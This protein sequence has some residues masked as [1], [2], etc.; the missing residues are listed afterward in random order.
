MSHRIKLIKVVP[1]FVIALFLLIVDSSIVDAH[2]SLE[3][4]S[5]KN[6]EVLEVSPSVIEI[7]FQDPVILHS[8][9]VKIID[10]TGSEV[11]IKETKLSSQD[12]GN[13]NVSLESK[14]EPGKYIVRINV[15]ALD[16]Y[17]I[18]EEFNFL[19][20]KRASVEEDMEFKLI[21]SSIRD[22]EII[23]GSP[24][25][26]ELWFNHPAEVSAFGLFNDQ[27][28]VIKTKI[29][30]ANSEDPSHIII[31]FSEELDQGTYQVTWYASPSE[32]DKQ[33]F[34]NNKQG[35]FY[36]AVDEFSSLSQGTGLVDRGLIWS[37]LD[38]TFELKQI[39]YWFIFIGLSLLFGFNWFHTMV[40]KNQ[41]WHYQS[42]TLNIFLFIVSALGI[43]LMVIYQRT[44]L[45]ELSLVEFIQLKFTW[46]PIVQFLLLSLGFLIKKIRLLL[47]GLTLLML[48]FVIGH[49]SYPRYGGYVTMAISYLHVLSVA[50]WMGGLL[51]LLLKPK[52]IKNIE[53][54]KTAGVP[55]TKW[56]LLSV[57]VI[58]FSGIAMTFQFLPSFSLGSLFVSEWGRALVIKTILFIILVVIGYV[59]RKTIL[60]LNSKFDH[61][62]FVKIRAELFFGII[63]FL[64]AATLV[65]TNPGVAEQGV[66]LEK[67]V[68]EDLALD[69]K[70]TPFHVGQNTITLQFEED[71]TIRNVSVVLSMPPNWKVERKAFEVDDRTYKL[72]GNLLHAPGT[73]KMNV[74]VELTNGKEIQIPYRIV[75][76]GET[77]FNES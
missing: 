58:I 10:G 47:F 52:S 64:F 60:N 73:L 65:A 21:R 6:G 1:L 35:V 40:T 49:A 46:I 11:Q 22:G 13:I 32:V 34:S 48:P 18:K 44:E 27:Q 55:F 42:L 8:E 17:S 75:V 57:G 20:Q 2:S 25:Q 77:R 53:W 72:T 14:L 15:L 9:S 61:S 24:D 71:L 16:G 28:E 63:V 67:N 31:P 23:K 33:I 5:P 62:F 7:T 36:F 56:A 12:A 37:I 3:K 66:Y 43:T 41:F 30:M 38:F 54:I 26:L 68:K 69:V 19:I 50:I 4:T 39:A 45:P 74:S 70:V 51:A 76:P 59:Q 29:P